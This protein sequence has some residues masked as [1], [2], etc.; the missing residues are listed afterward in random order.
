MHVMSLDPN[1]PR[2][3]EPGLFQKYS[4]WLVLG[5]YFLRPPWGA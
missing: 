2:E 1:N 4:Q 5:E 3:N